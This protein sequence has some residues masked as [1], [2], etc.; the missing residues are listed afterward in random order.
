ML[1]SSR[2]IDNPVANYLMA[3]KTQ[4]ERD[5]TSFAPAIAVD[6]LANGF[7]IRGS[8]NINLGTG[9]YIYIAWAE[10]PFGSSNTSPA[11][12]R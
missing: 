8:N 7:K 10:N 5:G 2:S 1:D 9:Q 12:A 3:N 4:E 11:N 6:F